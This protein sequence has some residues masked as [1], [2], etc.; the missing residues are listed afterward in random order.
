MRFGYFAFAWLLFAALPQ[1]GAQQLRLET[2]HQ[3]HALQQESARQQQHFEQQVETLTGTRPVPD[4]AEKSGADCPL[5]EFGFYYL[6]ASDTFRLQID[7]LLLG[8]GGNTTLQLTECVP[9]QFGT[10]TLDSTGLEYIPFP[11]VAAGIDTVCVDFCLTP[12]NCIR[13]EYPIVVKRANQTHILDPVVLQGEEFLPELCL[14][15]TLLP[16][17]L[18]CNFF[19][20]CPDNYDGEGRQFF[21]FTTV[22]PASCIGYRASRFPGVDSVCVVLCDVFTVCDT[23]KIPFRIQSDTLSLPFF[24][25]F[26]YEGP[27]PSSQ[28]WLDR[29]GYVNNTMSR[30]QP[31]IGMLTMDGVDR[32]GLAYPGNSGPADRLTSKPIDLS[33]TSGEVFLK[34]YSSPKGFGLYPNEGDTLV[35]EFRNSFGIWIPIETY[36]GIQGFIPLDSVPPFT[37][38]S[39]PIITQTF[40]HN[41]FQFRFTNYVS[42]PGMYDLWHLDYI[43]LDDNE[44]PDPAFQDVAFTRRPPSLLQRY[45]TMPWRHFEN[46]IEQE[47]YQGNFPS[48]FFNHFNETITVTQSAIRL[49][50]AGG[51]LFPGSDN[52]V[53]GQDANIPSRTPVTR[54]KELSPATLS[55]YKL[56]LANSFPDA[57]EVDLQLSYSLTV[58][59]QAAPFL[60]NDTV[61]FNTRFENTFGYDDGSAESYLFFQNPQNDNPMLAL[62]F[63]SNV[64]D[65]LRA[66]QFHFPQVH[67]NVQNQLFNMYVWVGSL[68]EE[69]AYEAFFKRALYA[70]SK[71]DTI[72]GYTTYRLENILGELEP[73]FLPAGTDFYIGFQQ[74]STTNEGIPIGYDLSRDA[75]NEVMVNLVGAW[76]AFPL[77]TA[78]A[79][80][81]RAVV[82]DETPVNTAVRKEK[83][84]Q[85]R[86]LK[87]F[88]N[89]STGLLRLEP[90]GLQDLPGSLTL[91]YNLQG[92]ELLRQP[93]LP[94]LNLEGLPAGMY[95]IQVVNQQHRAACITRIALVK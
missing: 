29:D 14:D 81:I 89:P 26:S 20:H 86:T 72:M 70:S 24:D 50:E 51:L 58:A 93:F 42:P 57:E 79:P 82:G 5:F 75:R 49:T 34:F 10:A 84:V 4:N 91:V 88:P 7:T 9:L 43:W 83:A 65:T 48:G 54:F 46:H 28:Y 61:R 95:L 45:S 11:G 33:N 25:D 21:Y 71:F 22:R 78:G 37:F 40:L 76:Q 66:V 64:D 67:G 47:F 23:F 30:N 12:D 90:E 3:N 94:E 19:L 73:V 41:A 1:V 8:G 87:A 63:T 44:G 55:D 52:V 31:S 15:E 68:N 60:R 18:Y 74:V 16:G 85:I 92:Q 35:L 39:I 53:D 32:R 27:Y 36:Q 13:F 69:P 17:D 2:L 77:S 80:M 59:A 56:V 62:R 6:L 38:R